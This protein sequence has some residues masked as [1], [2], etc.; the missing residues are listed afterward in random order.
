MNNKNKDINNKFLQ[1]KGYGIK[2]DGVIRLSDYSTVILRVF[3]SVDRI[4]VN[5]KEL[6][7]Y[8]ASINNLYLFMPCHG[9]EIGPIKSILMI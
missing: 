9:G 2:E 6:V 4:K 7:K 5:L 1:L 3:L 8:S